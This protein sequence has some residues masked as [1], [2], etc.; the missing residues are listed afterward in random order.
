MY[1]AK[2]DGQQDLTREEMSSTDLTANPGQG[3][4]IPS[5]QTPK[6]RQIND[7]ITHIAKSDN[8]LYQALT[9]LQ[10]QSN[11]IIG[12][13]TNWTSWNPKISNDQNIVVPNT[14]LS[15][16]YM[17]MW[18]LLFIELHGQITIPNPSAFLQISLPVDIGETI[19]K[20]C[21]AYLMNPAYYNGAIG[22]EAQKQLA[23]VYVQPL[24]GGINCTFMMGGALGIIQGS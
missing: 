15:A 24:F 13:I 18:N 21:A 20:T 3:T 7:L 2:L 5:T 6:K 10:S 11:S 8:H 22:V 9:S 19:L 4:V 12:N 14:E 16:Y 1:L 17:V 23:V